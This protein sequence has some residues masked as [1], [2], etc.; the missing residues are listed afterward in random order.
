M[1]VGAAPIHR[2]VIEFFMK[3]NMPI[4]ELYGMSEC[5]GPGSTNTIEEWRL[6]SVGK[7]MVGSRMKIHN[8]D[9][10]GEGEV[11]K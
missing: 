9:E 7:Q 6:G 11:K 3:Y 2:D 5:S 4:L 8:P 1:H 10:Y